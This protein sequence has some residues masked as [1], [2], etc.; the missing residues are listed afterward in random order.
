MKSS[1]SEPWAQTV[2]C[3]K[4]KIGFESTR[5][6]LYDAWESPQLCIMDFSGRH[7][8]IRMLWI[9]NLQIK[10]LCSFFCF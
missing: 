10:R 4:D 2:Q 1:R 8:K 5:C 6:C 3:E 7:N 9:L